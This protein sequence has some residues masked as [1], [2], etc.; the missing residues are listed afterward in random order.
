M[1]KKHLVEIGENVRSSLVINRLTDGSLQ[2]FS[3]KENI[4]ITEICAMTFGGFVTVFS[5]NEELNDALSSLRE[6]IKNERLEDISKFLGKA[7][8]YFEISKE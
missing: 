1:K 5:R 2:M 6:M 8:V 3:A 7:A 4:G